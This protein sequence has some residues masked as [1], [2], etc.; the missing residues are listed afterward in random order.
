[1][2]PVIAALKRSADI[3]NVGL[4]QQGKGAVRIEAT[5]KYAPYSDA[6]MSA[7][8]RVRANVMAAGPGSAFVA[9]ATAVEADSRAFAAKDNRLIM[10]VALLVVTLILM[11]LLRALVAPV[12]LMLTVVA[13]FVAVLGASYVAFTQLFGFPGVDEYIP[14]F[15]FIFLVALGADYNIFLMARVREEALI[16]GPREG[17][18]RGLVVTGG[19][20]TSAGIVLAGTFLVLAAMPITMLTEIG[21]AIALGVLFDA[22]IVRTALVPALGFALGRALWWPSRLSRPRR[23]LPRPTRDPDSGIPFG[24]IGPDHS[25]PLQPAAA[26]PVHA[27]DEPELPDWTRVR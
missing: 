20:I 16:H 9:G 24:W 22:L 23:A 17:M 27:P 6:A 11:L 13:S 21:F 3:A 10:P 19:V 18:R 15:V 14:L 7:I 1:V 25:S 12:V 26:A 8:D 5:L 4:V 2:R